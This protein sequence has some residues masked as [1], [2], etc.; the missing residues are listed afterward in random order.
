MLLK[1][2]RVD[3]SLRR[4]RRHHSDAPGVLL[5]IAPFIDARIDEYIRNLVLGRV[6]LDRLILWCADRT[7]EREYLVLLSHPARVGYSARRLVGV[8]QDHEFDLA[9]LAVAHLNTAC[10]I[11]GV[12]LELLAF[13]YHADHRDHTGHRRLRAELD[14]GIGDAGRL[15]GYGA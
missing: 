3:R 2:F 11:D 8:I 9:R 10:C 15:R 6:G 13:G 14:R 4:E 1:I 12:E 5:L 7:D